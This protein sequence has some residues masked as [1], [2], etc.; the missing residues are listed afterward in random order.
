M[1]Y[2]TNRVLQDNICPCD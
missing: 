1:A 2:L